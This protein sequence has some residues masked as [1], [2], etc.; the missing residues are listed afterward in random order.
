V[1]TFSKSLQLYKLY[2]FSLLGTFVGAVLMSGSV[3]LSDM[4][5]PTPEVQASDDNQVKT[6]PVD[7]PNSAVQPDRN[8]QNSDT[9]SDTKNGKKSKSK[10]DDVHLSSKP[11]KLKFSPKMLVTGP[12]RVLKALPG[13]MLGTPIATTKKVIDESKQATIDLAGDNRNLF[14]L[15]VLGLLGVPAGILSGGTEGPAMAAVNGWKY[16]DQKPFSK[17]Y[18]SLGEKNQAPVSP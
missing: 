12:E 2:G 8:N 10:T 4:P 16:A 14:I 15:S 17:E 11:K 5:A 13:F 9:V 1:F 3:A 18:F 6:R 7:Q